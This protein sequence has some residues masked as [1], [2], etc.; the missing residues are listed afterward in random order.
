M[1][2]KV[3]IMDRERWIAG[4][5]AFGLAGMVETEIFFIGEI[6]QRTKDCLRTREAAFRSGFSS[7]YISGFHKSVVQLLD[8]G[9]EVEMFL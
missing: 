2:G 3:L 4:T 6:L 9:I 1:N 8:F 7:L 5:E